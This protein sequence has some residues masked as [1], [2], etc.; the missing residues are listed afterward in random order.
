[1]V[2]RYSEKTV[3][4]TT[5]IST[6][7]GPG[8]SSIGYERAGCDVRLALDCAP[9]KF[10]N[11]IPETYRQNHQTT[12]FIEQ[13]ASETCAD[14][15]LKHANVER[16]ELDI[17]DGSPPCS[18]FS[19]ANN[20]KVWGDHESGTLFDRYTYFVEELQ[21]RTF[22][23]ENVPRLAEGKT[24]GYYKQ[25]CQNLR[26]AGYNLSVQKIDAA[27]LGAAHHRR[28][29]IFIGVREDIG[30]PPTIQPKTTPIT[31]REAWH[32]LN[33]SKNQVQRVKKK[34]ER[35][36][37][38]SEFSKLPPDASTSTDEVRTDGKSSGFT[39]YRLSYRKPAPTLT[40]AH[41]DMIHPSEDR[42]LTIPEVK[43]I[44]GVP[45]EYKIP[46][47][48]CAIRCLPPVLTEEIATKIR[49]TVLAT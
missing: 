49:D 42:Y 7:S 34:A 5:V 36:D 22:V 25:L 8:G 20:T 23:A 29:L 31:V 18:P 9:G 40:S 37:W 11:A 26:D 32:N 41:K 1:V 47:W 13:N 6:F 16:T 45:D 21:P 35:S 19:N 4:K 30:H 12:A 39:Q 33:Q 46:N 14:D 3:S 43:R 38:Y 48:E 27:Y 44:I 28:R 15:L 17:L 2:G 10:S 24:K